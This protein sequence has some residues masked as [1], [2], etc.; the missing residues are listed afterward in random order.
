[1]KN[2]APAILLKNVMQATIV[3][4]KILPVAIIV[5]LPV[6]ELAQKVPELA[7]LFLTEHR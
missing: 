6:V 3:L 1:V 4:L 7:N 5:R 2:S